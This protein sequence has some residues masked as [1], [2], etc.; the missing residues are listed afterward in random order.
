MA[1]ADVRA[2]IRT[3][4]TARSY[5]AAT[6]ERWLQLCPEDAK[7]LLQLA[8]ELRLGENQL[9]GLWEWSEEIA[10]RDGLSLARVLQHDSVRA[11]LRSNVGRNDRLKLV[12]GA[13]RRLRFPQL[14]AVE[15]QLAAL[16]RELE[17]PRNVRVTLPAFLEGESVRIEITADTDRAWL[18]AAVSLQAA[19]EHPA[20]KRLFELLGE[21]Q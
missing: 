6:T 11:G 9:R 12:K 17:L 19:A 18:A 8:T 2:D 5:S 7:A 4:A 1:G 10:Q 14:A 20:C 16:I 3:Y 21:A 15:Q 13:L